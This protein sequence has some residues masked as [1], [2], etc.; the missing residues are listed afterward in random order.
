MDASIECCLGNVGVESRHRLDRLRKS[1][2][3]GLMPAVEHAD[4]RRFAQRQRCAG[5]PESLRSKRFGSAMPLT[6]KPYLGSE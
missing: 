2:T 5:S 3:G 4:L 1:L 6:A